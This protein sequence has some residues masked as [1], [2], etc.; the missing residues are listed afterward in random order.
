MVWAAYR[1]LD[2]GVTVEDTYKE[3][4]TMGFSSSGFE[5]K[6]KAYIRENAR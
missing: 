2:Q 3:I 6:T 1:T 5:A 4:E